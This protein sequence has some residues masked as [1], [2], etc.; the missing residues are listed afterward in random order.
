MEQG[1]RP[2]YFRLFWSWGTLAQIVSLCVFAFIFCYLCGQRGIFPLDQ[3]IVF[4]G[5]YRIQRGQIPFRDFVTP[6]SLLVL[7]FQSLL[8][9]VF[10]TSYS[11]YLLGAALLNVIA[12]V[13]SVRIIS[14]L[15]P[16]RRLSALSAGVLTSAWFLAPFGTPFGE[17]CA[18]LLGL[19]GIDC[20]LRALLEVDE[21]HPTAHMRGVV[22]AGFLAGASFYA[23]QNVALFLLPF[24]L[25][26]PLIVWTPD[27]RR[28]GVILLALLG[29][30]AVALALPLLFVILSGGWQNFSYFYVLLPIATALRRFSYGQTI[31]GGN[32]LS[33]WLAVV[34][35]VSAGLL[36]IRRPLSAHLHALFAARTRL[37]HE[38]VAAWLA[39]YCL[40]ISHF[41]RRSMLNNPTMA[42]VYIGLVVGIVGALV[43]ERDTRS[44]Q[45]YK[46][47]F[48]GFVAIVFAFG[49]FLS[50]Q[51]KV[52]ESVKDST[53]AQGLPIA[54]L[55]PLRWGEPTLLFDGDLKQDEEGLDLSAASLVELVEFLQSDDRNFFIF[56][57]FTF[58][59]AVTGKPSPQPLLFFHRGLTY[60]PEYDVAVDSWIVESLIAN[61]VGVV[62]LEQ[63]S[64][65]GTAKR[66]A[67]FPLLESFLS[68][69]FSEYRQIGPFKIL[70][71]RAVDEPSE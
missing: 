64:F 18:F 51:R 4:D 3:S 24:F 70:V 21:S 22:V 13:F 15:F 17:Q 50:W 38:S 33:L 42:D 14:I 46:K 69:N 23:K 40:L 53:F 57:D 25:C 68:S 29:G 41:L 62:V 48:L 60:P 27:W 10:G 45:R 5:A 44:A 26:T 16:Q 30:F 32:A 54:G 63:K 28:V 2:G 6:H 59:Y 20:L 35:V 11:S 67:D 43:V 12:V 56:P 1:A 58:L 31:A 7:Y 8:F 61:Q 9:S 66:L 71:L 47:V 49:C 39:L 37:M 55:E 36:S 19:I 65:F 52:H 34:V